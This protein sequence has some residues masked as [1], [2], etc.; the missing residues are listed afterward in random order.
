M[1]RF[2]RLILLRYMSA[3]ALFTP[4]SCGV[5]AHAQTIPLEMT[6]TAP[7]RLLVSG[8]RDSGF[9]YDGGGLDRP[10]DRVGFCIESSSPDIVLQVTTQNPERRGF[11]SL[12]AA[13]V[14]S[15]ISY[16]ST[17]M[18]S[19]DPVPIALRNAVSIPFNLSA[20][21]R[22]T[23]GCPE[24]EFAFFLDIAPLIEAGGEA[25]SVSEAIIAAD[26]LDAGEKVFSDIITL[27][28][29]LD[30]EAAP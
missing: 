7:H 13:G 14:S 6:I 25:V 21:D 22:G 3:A 8:G 29:S 24:N 26:L 15:H 10:S 2:I 23:D 19:S 28:F 4:L 12:E 5:A 27:T 17:G 16:E 20:M 1:K 11:S 30:L 9:R 18:F